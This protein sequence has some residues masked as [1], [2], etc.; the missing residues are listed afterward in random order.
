V[1]RALSLS[2]LL[3]L[4]A[5]GGRT[6]PPPSSTAPAVRA[7]ELAPLVALARG[8]PGAKEFPEAD[9]LVSL[10]RDDI[11]LEAD[12]GVTLHHRSVVKLL[13]AQRAKEKFADVHIPYDTR[14][15]ALTIVHA[16]TVNADGTVHP[17]SA[18][19]ISDIL[20]PQLVGATMYSGLLERVISFPAVD[21]GSVVELEYVRVTRSTPDAARG[22]E[23]ALATWDPVAVRTVTLT[24]PRGQPVR[25]SVEGMVLA[26]DESE[27]A[28]AGTHTWTFT[29]RDS[30]DRHPESGTPADAA[31]TPRLVYSFLPDWPAAA[32]PVAGRYLSAMASAALPAAVKTRS[33]ELTAGAGDDLERAR[34]LFAFVAHDIRS[35]DVPLGWAGYAPDAPEAV[36]ARRYG[37]GRDK[38]GLLVALCAAA[39]IAGTPVLVRTGGVPVVESVPTVAQ[40][41][42]MIVR[43]SVA[44]RPPLWLDPLDE[45]GQFAL[46]FAGQDNL[47]LPLVADGGAPVVR[48][49]LAADS[50]LAHAS[51]DYVLR[52]NG[53]LDARQSYAVS[54]W[55][56]RAASER[57]RALKGE[58]LQR[59]FQQLAAEFSPAALDAEHQVG[60]LE[61]VSG[62]I[63]IAQHIA[64]PGYAPAQGRFRVFELPPSAVPFLDLPDASLD[65]RKY[66]LWLGTPRT[67]VQ[68]V[69]LALPAEWTVVYAPAAIERSV[70]G[71]RYR[72]SCKVAGPRLTCHS[73]L[74]VERLQIAGAAYQALHRTM[75]ER[76]DYRRRV[77]L[78]QRA[79]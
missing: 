30:P 65:Q 53:D 5:C 71:L 56:A 34:R 36:L 70:P 45:H 74:A 79:P 9:A 10:D 31:F 7:D 19:E 76:D 37:D 59:Y 26:P 21:R 69:T 11:R 16:R 27:D 60:D 58:N 42:Q 63:A 24:A 35:V 62:P 20:P 15:E 12:G 18:E 44:G 72:S 13:D 48:P 38:V 73:E 54:G 66:P 55:F 52:S 3:W 4:G 32:R 46:G 43:L 22:G 57:L 50:S 75:A 51:Q 14:R 47:V 40:F 49:P 23:E 77:V 1:R 29:V 17:A 28:R 41:D 2:L 8:G 64:V 68:D 25:F 67:L 78:L 6:L 39:G 33:A 61:S